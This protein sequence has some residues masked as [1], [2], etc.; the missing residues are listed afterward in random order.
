MVVKDLMSYK[1]MRMKKSNEKNVAI[2]EDIGG[3]G[4]ELSFLKRVGSAGA[5]FREESHGP[6]ISVGGKSLPELY[7]LE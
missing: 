3:R 4:G 1:R 5:V 7:S 6:C 2:S